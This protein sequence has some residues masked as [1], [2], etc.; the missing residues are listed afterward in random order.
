MSFYEQYG[1]GIPLFSPSLDFLTHLHLQHFLVMEKNHQKP[2][3]QSGLQVH[4][5]YNG[6]ARTKLLHMTS[7]YVN[8]DPSDDFDARS[9]RYWLSLSDFF[10]FSH[11]VHFD[12]IQHLVDILQ[13]MWNEP[14][15]LNKINKA[16]RFE[17]RARLK[18]LLRYWR[19]RLIEI[20][21]S[22]PHKPE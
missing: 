13:L 14:F 9:V 1:M 18:F 12:S 16:M 21:Q 20:A 15:R 7:K 19:Q 6:S 11:V 17:N 10:T 3:R 4:V 8:L 2:N 22:S 5:A